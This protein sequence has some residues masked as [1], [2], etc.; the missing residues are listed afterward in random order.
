MKMLE[1]V[2]TLALL[3]TSA[4]GARLKGRIP[5]ASEKSKPLLIDGYTDCQWNNPMHKADWWKSMS[6]GHK[7]ATRNGSYQPQHYQIPNCK[8]A[9]CLPAKNGCTFWK[10]L[11][12]RMEGNPNWNHPQE[13]ARHH[14]GKTQLTSNWQVFK[15]KD[16]HTM[17]LVRNPVVRVLSAFL[18]K[19]A[20]TSGYYHNLLKPYSLSK[21]GF[22]M[23]VRDLAGPVQGHHADGHWRRQTDTCGLPEGA[24]WDFYLK[25][26]CRTLWGPSLF[27]K[28]NLHRWTDSG[29]GSD[30]KQPFIP[31]GKGSPVP[32]TIQGMKANDRWGT[33]SHRADQVEKVCE[34]YTETNFMN[35]V[36]LYATD[37]VSFGYFDDV[38]RLAQACHFR[39][40]IGFPPH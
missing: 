15:E 19:K 36:T 5:S 23:F 11:F 9:M 24:H 2:A 10:A 27:D 35:V 40:S 12:M 26:E 22:E 3:V 32:T 34:W 25:V 33:H 21:W 4:H 14:V 31:K 20:N 6:L 16:A 18:D 1:A 17:M 39:T 37:I 8:A 30:G 28:Y 29:W 38:H 13:D 7:A